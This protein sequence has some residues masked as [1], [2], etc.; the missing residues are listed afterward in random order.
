MT[1]SKHFAA[2]FFTCA[3]FF[4]CTALT[5]PALADE[6]AGKLLVLPE[7]RQPDYADAG[8]PPALPVT[9]Q[10]DDEERE[11]LNLDSSEQELIIINH[12][13]HKRY[14]QVVKYASLLVDDPNLSDYGRLAYTN[15]LGKAY[16]AL[17]E[18]DSAIHYMWENLW[19]FGEPDD[20]DDLPTDIEEDIVGLYHKFSK[21]TTDNVYRWCKR[22]VDA[23]KRQHP[24]TIPNTAVYQPHSSITL[25]T[26][27]DTIDYLLGS[28]SLGDEG[29]YYAMQKYWQTFF[30]GENTTESNRNTKIKMALAVSGYMLSTHHTDSAVMYARKAY[31]LSLKPSRLL[32]GYI[33]S[34]WLQSAAALTWALIEHGKPDQALQLQRQLWQE[35][36]KTYNISKDNYND[37][38][39]YVKEYTDGLSY[40][41][42]MTEVSYISQNLL[43]ETRAALAVTPRDR[44]VIRNTHLLWQNARVFGVYE[45][46]FLGDDYGEFLMLEANIAYKNK[47]PE[48]LDYNL[49]ELMA[50]NI[51]LYCQG[52][53]RLESMGNGQYRVIPSNAVM[54]RMEK[55]DA[56]FDE[57]LRMLDITGSPALAKSAYVGA[58][59][60]K[61]RQ[62]NSKYALLPA[63]G[64]ATSDMSAMMSAEMLAQARQHDV[65]GAEQTQ[66]SIDSLECEMAYL[67]LKEDS[68]AV[69][70]QL[71]VIDDVRSA[72]KDG[73]V[74]VEFVCFN[75]RESLVYTGQK[76]YGA[77]IVTPQSKQVEYVTLCTEEQLKPFLTATEK[78]DISDAYSGKTL[79]N[80]IWKPLKK[81]LKGIKT[82]YYAPMGELNKVA[83]EAAMPGGNEAMHDAY[84][85]RRI[86]S[87]GDIT[88]KPAVMPS[89]ALT[90]D[91]YGD[92]T[93]SLGSR[94]DNT[95]HFTSTTRDLRHGVGHLDMSGQ[96]IDSV[97]RII[98]RQGGNFTVYSHDKATEASFIA[99]SGH[100]PDIIHVASHAFAWDITTAQASPY[101]KLTEMPLLDVMRRCGILFAGANKA[102][103]GRGRQDGNDGVL[104]AAEIRALDL[105]GT[106]LVVLSA[107]GTALGETDIE[108]VQG[109]QKAFF[110]AGAKNLVMTLWNVDDEATSVFMRLFYEELFGD[111]ERDVQQALD[112]AKRR[113]RRMP[114][115]AE[116]YY[117]AAFI[118]VHNSSQVAAEMPADKSVPNKHLGNMAPQLVGQYKFLKSARHKKRW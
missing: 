37:Y 24:V 98:G 36:E 115:Y 66:H 1:I 3:I 54:T 95:P 71:K 51:R 29:K 46:E 14:D 77:L 6:D 88:G 69:W 25:R 106:S 57:L 75:N 103:A 65:I 101:Y 87:T 4:L 17:N 62:L 9:R 16:M 52:L 105:S 18:P 41:A 38:L 94:G 89:G 79:Y 100:S 53:R 49:T 70:R 30:E 64:D 92:I 81:H 19:V 93:Y 78:R 32:I 63:R 48:T 39:Y 83:L 84:T 7:A 22:R 58:L 86:L 72:L 47:V 85:M 10:L 12:E 112:N 82:I 35:L 45:K 73:E 33:S 59:Y 34:Q 55:Y 108:G 50:R 91:L 104:T 13:K 107:C 23:Y 42:R 74:A 2:L 56:V 27:N 99:L 114:Q 76:T 116:P 111:A 31:E 5:T 97:A 43:A 21:D 44:A 26:L 8:E 118:A 11:F 67:T 110:E 60:Y 40:Y 80:L 96:E 113:M 117:W 15:R 90:A 20:D 61:Q 28:N 102:L 109:L 68:M